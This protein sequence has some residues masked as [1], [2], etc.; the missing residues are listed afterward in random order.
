MK[1]PADNANNNNSTMPSSNTEDSFNVKWRVDVTDFG[2][3]QT[4]AVYT[5]LRT[6]FVHIIPLLLLCIIN[7]YLIKFIR[8]ANARWRGGRKTRK[9]KTPSSNPLIE[10]RPNL[11][12]KEDDTITSAATLAASRRNERRQAAQRKLTVLLVAIV[13]LF[14]AGQI[15]QAFAYVSN[16]QVVLRLFGRSSQSLACCPPYRM[17]RAITNCICLITY[18]AN[19]FLYASLNSHFKHQLN[20]WIGM[21][22]WRRRQTVRTKTVNAMD[23]DKYDTIE[24]VD[25]RLRMKETVSADG[26][27]VKRRLVPRKV[28]LSSISREV[29]VTDPIAVSDDRDRASFYSYSDHVWRVSVAVLPQAGGRPVAL[30]N[31]TLGRS[32]AAIPSHSTSPHGSVEG[33]HPASSLPTNH[34]SLSSDIF[35]PTSSNESQPSV[36]LRRISQSVF[37]SQPLLKQAKEDFSTAPNEKILVRVHSHS[38]RFWSKRRRLLAETRKRVK[39]KKT[40]H[41]AEQQS[42]NENRFQLNVTSQRFHGMGHQCRNRSNLQLFLPPYLAT[43]SWCPPFV[44]ASLLRANRSPKNATKPSV[45]STIPITYQETHLDNIL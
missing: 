45:R 40:D 16:V 7:F 11:H 20:E 42:L 36:P 1:Y 39:F 32:V 5:W 27:Q 28:A 41:P 13:G 34:K 21:C 29:P 44:V 33:P 31:A 23:S 17:Y 2:K 10:A 9:L 3:S 24:R 25:H 18:S 22:S 8:I 26:Y 37:N 19:F 15:P 12:A 35:V 4:Y 14:L 30:A 6:V 38:K 43:V